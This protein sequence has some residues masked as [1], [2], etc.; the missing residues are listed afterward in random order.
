M[1]WKYPMLEQLGRKL[2]WLLQQ[3]GKESIFP[4]NLS[5]A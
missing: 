4:S 3:H 5:A 1:E 2:S